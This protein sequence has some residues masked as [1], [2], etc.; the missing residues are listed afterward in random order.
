LQS[1][2]SWNWQSS[3]VFYSNTAKFFIQSNHDSDLITSKTPEMSNSDV[4]VGLE[5]TAD[6]AA[7][8]AALEKADNIARN[9]NPRDGLPLWKW[10]LVLLGL[11]LGD[12]LYG[13]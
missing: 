13:T 8:E 9:A 4:E 5:K 3:L 1:H 2:F 11:F 7:A 10:I 12:L 6:I